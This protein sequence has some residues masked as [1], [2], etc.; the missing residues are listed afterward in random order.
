MDNFFHKTFSTIQALVC[1]PQLM[2][3]LFN[4]IL[5]VLLVNCKPQ[6]CESEIFSQGKGANYPPF[7]E[8]PLLSLRGM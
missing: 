5:F 1:C 6:N 7:F 3:Y 2:H 8:N 4:P